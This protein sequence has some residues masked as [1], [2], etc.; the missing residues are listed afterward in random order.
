[1][2]LCDSMYKLYEQNKNLLWD[3]AD[4][5]DVEGGANEHNVIPH[6]ISH[7]QN[8]LKATLEEEH[9]MQ[10]DS[11]QGKNVSNLWSEAV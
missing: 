6:S 7:E 4:Y 9:R 5:S 2:V 11:F 3:L 1:M 10:W 8:F